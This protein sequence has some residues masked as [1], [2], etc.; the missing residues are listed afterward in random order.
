MADRWLL[1]H[2]IAEGVGYAVCTKT[3]NRYADIGIIE[4]RRDALGR[5]RYRQGAI[6]ALAEYLGLAETEPDKT[7]NNNPAAASA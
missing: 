5:R 3:V 6:R 7:A 2:E 4:C 1:A